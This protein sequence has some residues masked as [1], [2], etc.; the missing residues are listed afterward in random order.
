[1]VWVKQD[2]VIIE[3]L[4]KRRKSKEAGEQFF[5]DKD[6]AASIAE[7]PAQLQPNKG[8]L[9]QDQYKVYSDF[10]KLNSKTKLDQPSL[11]PFPSVQTGEM[12]FMNS[13][14]QN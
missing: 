12:Q 8:G 1:M 6:I 4:E 2:P 3:A 9:T 13:L 10:A 11:G 7:L 14:D 5:V